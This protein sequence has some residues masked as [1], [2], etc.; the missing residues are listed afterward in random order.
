MTDVVARSEFS[1]T[2][3]GHQPEI[4]GVVAGGAGKWVIDDVTSRLVN[5]LTPG[6]GRARCAE[7]EG[8]LEVGS[9]AD[10]FVVILR[11]VGDEVLD[12]AAHAHLTERTNLDP[13]FDLCGLGVT[14]PCTGVEKVSRPWSETLVKPSTTKYCAAKSRPKVLPTE[15]LDGDAVV[16]VEFETVVHLDVAE[17]RIVPEQ[18]AGA[19]CRPCLV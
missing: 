19:V 14:S 10:D 5:E 7:V 9:A 15:P 8:C 18:T 16:R 17:E 3:T 12:R 13:R 1:R 4:V 6:P 2:Y 11:D